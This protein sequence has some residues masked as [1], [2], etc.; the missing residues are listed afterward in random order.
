M[1]VTKWTTRVLQTPADNPL[2]V[3]IPQ[4]GTREF[5]TLEVDTDE[6]LSGIGVTF[7]GGPLTPALRTAVDNLCEL[8][9]GEDPLQ[10][11]A[12]ADKLRLAAGSAGPEGIFTLALAAIDMALWDIKGK[13]LN[14][15]VCSL[16][17]GHRDRVNTYASGAC[18]ADSHV[19]KKLVAFPRRLGERRIPIDQLQDRYD[20]GE[21]AK[22]EQ[23]RGFKFLLT[24]WGVRFHA[25]RVK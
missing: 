7:F 8:T 6:G 15:S 10:V 25:R 21:A 12:V 9:V 4:P 24:V 5:V 22:D 1:K 16:L 19:V 2:V 11:E 17:G 18:R 23:S 20:Q 13:A 14:Q 3:G